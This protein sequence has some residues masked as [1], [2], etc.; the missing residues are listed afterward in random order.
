MGSGNEVEGTGVAD[1]GGSVLE[2]TDSS[3]SLIAP[4]EETTSS[5][6]G[7]GAED[8]VEPCW[9]PPQAMARRPMTTTTTLS[10]DRELRLSFLIKGRVTLKCM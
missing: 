4:D 9:S 3:G 10:F 7:F 6:L 1:V 2:L 5:V 8:S